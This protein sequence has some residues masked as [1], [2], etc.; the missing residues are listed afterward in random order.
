MTKFLTL[1]DIEIK[2]KIVLV[3]VDFN[4]PVDPKSKKILDDTRI[5]AHSETTLKELVK[6]GGRVVILAHQGRLGS[7]DFI[8][9]E[10]HA[11]ILRKISGTMV[12]YIDDLYGEDART[13]IEALKDGEMLILKNTRTFPHERE[14][15]SPREHSQSVFVKEL[16][17]IAD[18]FVND[19]FS[20]AHRSHASVV[21]FSEVLPSV[22]GRIMEREIN[23]L[24]NL[25]KAPK[26]PCV[27]VLGGAKADD[28]LEISRYVLKNGIADYVLTGGV[29]SQLFLMA[30]GFDLGTIN[31]KFLN[32]KNILDLIPGIQELL[33]RFP[34]K[35]KVPI[36]VAV[37][38]DS[39][40]KELLTSDLPTE[41]SIFDIGSETIKDY[42]RIIE[43]AKS[44]VIS[45]P[46]GVYEQ[47]PFQKGTKEILRAIAESKAFSVVGGGHT[48]GA[49]KEFGF[50]DN[51]SYKST[52][53]GALIEFLMGKTLPGLTALGWS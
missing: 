38:A 27:F 28:S 32:K 22:A 10:Q 21:G 1:N 51:I 16:A 36:D 6:K 19:A 5:R 26:K 47:K 4:S 12:E 41:N 46:L 48:L 52:A 11:D 53:G 23:V 39:C 20:V 3:R 43:K 42:L 18:V 15:K 35:I 14:S 37:D 45:G 34:K 8:S 24:S 31:V 30:K 2:G 44:I 29:T 17:S 7:S 33:T 50:A 9:L 13:A 49:V 25:L 40:R